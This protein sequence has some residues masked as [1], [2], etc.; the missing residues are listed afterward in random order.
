MDAFELLEQE[1]L[2]K[3]TD[4]LE[5]GGDPNLADSD[6]GTLLH[7][8]VLLAQ[9]ET[10]SELVRFGANINYEIPEDQPA[11]DILAPTCLSLA[12]QCRH[13]MDREKFSPI[14]DL[15]VLLGAVDET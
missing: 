15:L 4:Y 11:H 1:S 3:L 9:P 7:Y 6:G 10:I 2:P 12:Q 5:G 13:L 14:V 8:A